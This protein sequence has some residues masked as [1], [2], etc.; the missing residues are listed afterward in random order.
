MNLRT[1][2]IPA[3]VFV[4]STAA[5]GLAQT[6]SDHDHGN[7]ANAPAGPQ[8]VVAEARVRGVRHGL[9]TYRNR[10]GQRCIAQGELRDGRI[11]AE[12]AG[13]FRRM[14]L[15]EGGG[16]CGAAGQPL[17]YAVARVTDDPATTADETR[18]EIFGMAAPDVRALRFETPRFDVDIPLQE[19]NGFLVVV[20]EEFHGRARFVVTRGDGRVDRVVLPDLEPMEELSELAERGA[21]GS[22]GHP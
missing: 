18:T 2:V 16:I 7:A 5:V 14:P 10:D 15:E 9:V 22:G 20:E 12:V 4:V 1:F 13:E 17:N 3:A 6:A 21:A 8:S 11:G 19:E